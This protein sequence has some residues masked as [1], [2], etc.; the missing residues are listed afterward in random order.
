LG[1]CQKRRREKGKREGEKKKEHLD[2]FS[3]LNFLLQRKSVS[4][5]EEGKKR[6]SGKGGRKFRPPKLALRGKKNS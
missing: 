4:G 5:K 1:L 6:R 3:F 2:V